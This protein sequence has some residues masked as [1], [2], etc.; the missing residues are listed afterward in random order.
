MHLLRLCRRVRASL[1]RSGQHGERECDGAVVW[2]LRQGPSPLLPAPPT[3]VAPA[4]TPPGG[5]LGVRLHSGLC[6][7]GPRPVTGADITV[8]AQGLLLSG[9]TDE[10][11]GVERRLRTP[12]TETHTRALFIAVETRRVAARVTSAPAEGAPGRRRRAPS[13]KE[14]SHLRHATPRSAA[15]GSAPL[16]FGSVLT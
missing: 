16:S 11:L 2:D 1:H 6:I 14:G 10:L 8:L 4:S 3:S 9:M 7:W 12:A 13:W 15:P 5:S